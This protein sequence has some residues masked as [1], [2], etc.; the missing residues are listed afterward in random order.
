MTTSVGVIGAGALG[1]PIAALLLKRGFPVSVRDVRRDPVERLARLGARP[2]ASSAELARHSDV[3]ISLV[4]DE[5]Q[6][7]DVVFGES[8][9]LAGLQRGAIVAIG[10]T[11]GPAPVR[12]IAAALEAKGAHLLD[13]PISGGLVAAREGTLSLMAGGDPAVLARANAVLRVFARTITRAGDVGAGQTAKLAH[14][15]V[16]SVNVMALLEGLSLGVA[17]GVEPAVMKEI[18]KEGIANSGVLQLWAELGPR[19]KGM[20]EATAPG[21]TPP[22]LRKDL[23]LVLELAQELRVNLYIGSQ[24][25]LIA[26]AGIATGR[27]D[28]RI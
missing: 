23:H 9:V 11:L 24:A 18:L 28:A 4:L 14:Q 27:D 26:D 21:V 1:E 10:S 15:L 16:F 25:S 20:L 17:G 8:G 6:T 13:M 7:M 22:N 19:W 3:I 5:R 2:C 12:K